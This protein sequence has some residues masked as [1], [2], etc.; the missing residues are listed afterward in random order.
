MHL[1]QYFATMIFFFNVSC[2]VFS[3]FV[4]SVFCF[5]SFVFW[6]FVIRISCVLPILFHVDIL[7]FDVR[8]LL[9]FVFR[10][11]YSYLRYFVFKSS[12][13][14][15]LYLIYFAFNI[16]SRRSVALDIYA[17][18]FAFRYFAFNIL[19]GTRKNALLSPPLANIYATDRTL[20]LYV[21]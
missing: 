4:T 12:S 21:M 14:D 17:P 18:Y 8:F 3:Y 15:I 5:Q 6:Y 1:I 20:V 9:C 2:F 16:W 7:S 11:M 10:F 13:F 19:S